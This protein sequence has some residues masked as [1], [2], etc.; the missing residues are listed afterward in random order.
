MRVVFTTFFSESKGGGIGRVSYEIAQAFAQQG[1]KTILICPGKKTQLKKVAPHLEYL[2]I[3]SIIE[4]D[5]A[6][7]YLTMPNLKFLFNF[8]E[9][10]SP[11]IVHGHDFGP[12]TLTAQFWVINH[13]IPFIYT[14]HV[15]PTKPADFAIGE[16]SKSLKRL[17]DTTLMKKY[18][19]LFF[20][21]CDALIALNKYIQKDI[22]EY[23]F[24]GK[25][26][27][28]PNGRYL[29]SYQ[30][31][32]PAKL[33]EKQKQLTFIGYL[34]TRKNQKYLCRVMEYLPENFVLNLIGVPINPKYLQELKT[35]VQKKSLK[36]V[37]FLGEVPYEK[38]PGL[39]EKTH[40][41]VS[42]SKMEVQS[43]VIIEALA[44]G[45]PVVG[46]SNETVSEFI[47]DSVGFLLGKEAHPRTFAKKVKKI[48]SLSQKE[49][50]FLCN[51][52]Q[53]RVAHLDW[54]D[55]VKQT[56]MVY[57]KLIKEKKINK[58]ERKV[59]N[60][61]VIL[62]MLHIPK[63]K[64]FLQKIVQKSGDKIN[65][66]KNILMFIMTIIGTFFLGIC[67]WFLN[68]TKRIPIPR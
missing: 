52:A 43:L 42:A 32:C 63:N 64:S 66:K 21:N 41:F 39:L 54:P 2:Q 36:N 3:R 27:T 67:Y 61:K 13:K 23:G 55:I 20:K 8:L 26:F 28:I 38:I 40:V 44:S 18:F 11:Q 56:E 19:F 16:F 58:G 35:Y 34:S 45:T 29:S 24:R 68:K 5:I 31:C 10:F 62:K 60:I 48:C 6:I 47:D 59:S 53:K 22:I 14:T 7:P 57:Q 37:N 65:K 17:M 46:L 25:V 15:L 12:L 30:R 4:G 33:S 9:E 51:N 1:H 49:Y 50:E